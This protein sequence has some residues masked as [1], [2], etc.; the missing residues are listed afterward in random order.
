[1]CIRRRLQTV[2]TS[3]TLVDERDTLIRRA[4]EKLIVVAMEVAIEAR[5]LAGREVGLV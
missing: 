4:Q 1:M 3:Q 5:Q 2:Q